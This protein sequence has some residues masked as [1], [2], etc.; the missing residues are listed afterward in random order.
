[1]GTKY[2]M[3]N[4]KFKKNILWLDNEIE[5]FRP[6]IK[7]LEKIGFNVDTAEN[8]LDA[9]ELSTRKKF[10]IIL[11]DL[12]MPQPDGVE[13]LQRI[14]PLQSQ[15]VFTVFSS[16]LYLNSYK[17]RLNNIE[18]P[19]ELLDKDFPPP[20]SDDFHDRFL[21]PI[22]DLPEKRDSDTNK[23]IK[24]LE[25]FN[26]FDLTYVDYVNL[27]LSEKNKMLELANSTALE[28]IQDAFDDGKIWVFLCGSSKKIRASAEKPDEILSEDEILEYAHLHQRAPYYFFRTLELDEIWPKYGTPN[29]KDFYPTVTL[30]INKIQSS[31]HFDTG[32]PISIISYEKLIE[33]GIIRPTQLFG[34][35]LIRGGQIYKAIPLHIEAIV[36][37]QKTG[38]AKMVRISGQAVVDWESSPF[39]INTQDNN[40]ERFE[41][42]GLIG[43]NF[44]TENKLALTLDGKNLVTILT[45]N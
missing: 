6:Y 43:R 13:A 45:S 3:A 10:D 19:V 42:I 23:Y 20:H 16:F 26:P 41:R 12:S 24:P 32:A 34:Q 7:E 28:T 5:H 38:S 35:S 1:M 44:L 37:C 36:R 15:A 2:L 18:F 4:T 33:M 30:E 27:P 9:V 31:M 17:Q 25:G 21:K 39:A 40:K 22:C 8:T 14:Y 11:I 29:T